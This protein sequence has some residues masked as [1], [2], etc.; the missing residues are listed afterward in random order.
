MA[1]DNIHKNHRQ[2]MRAK[3]NETGF[4]G[5]SDYEILEYMLYNVYRQGDTNPVAHEI[6]RYSGGSIVNVMR[7]ARD[8]T[9]AENVKNVGESA[10]LFLR[11]LK[12]FI[13]YYRREELEYEPRRLDV[14][15]LANIINIIGFELD[16]EDIL[17]ICMDRFM[18]VKSITNITEQSGP[19]YAYTSTEKIFRTATISGAKYVM[20]VHNHPDGKKEISHDDIEMTLHVDNMLHAMDIMLVDH[21]VICGK[22]VLSIKSRV[23]KEEMQKA[24]ENL[25]ED[26]YYE[27]EGPF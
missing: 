16:R 6:L 9:M 8:F 19:R 15:N 27:F 5:W 17:M 24:Q 21:M 25:P 3:F 7:N 20:L 18:N 10:V 26:M 4:N 2:R 23:I 11:S 22:E 1:N 14:E 13:D 12:E